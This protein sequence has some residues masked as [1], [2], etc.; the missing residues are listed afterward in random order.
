MLNI[1]WFSTGRDKAARQLLQAVQECITTGDIK[2]KINFVFS[3]REPGQSQESDLFFD[4]V[5]SYNIPLVYFSRSKF[6]TLTQTPSLEGRGPGE[7]KA[8][9]SQVDWRLK[10]DTEVT[11]RIEKFS[12]DLCVLAG[13]MLIIGK[14]LCQKY[15][16]INL[17]PAAPGGPVGSWQE[18]IWKLIKNKAEEAGAMIHLVTPELDR[19]PVVSYCLFPIKHKPFDQYWQK[20]DQEMLFKLIRQH[21]LAREFPLI[22]STLKA[23]SQGKISIQSGKIID[24]Q[25]NSIQGYNLTGEINQAL[26]A[27]LT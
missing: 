25:G 26:K 20:E 4:L 12:P 19:G 13:Y 8:K 24:T 18:V 27:N 11:R 21:E 2:G 3:N 6:K 14:E 7:D 9:Q 10:Y 17:H 5:R 15:N 22:T 16:M 23:L 1:G